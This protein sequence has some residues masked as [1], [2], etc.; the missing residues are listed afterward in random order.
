MGWVLRIFTGNVGAFLNFDEPDLLL[1]DSTM[2]LKDAPTG[3]LTETLTIIFNHHV[4]ANLRLLEVCAGL[5]A[6]Q[7]AASMPAARGSI[8]ETLEHIVRSEQSYFSRISTG[9]PLHRPDNAPP[10]NFDPTGP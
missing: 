7:L 6:E 1:E 3:T 8:Q 9:K 4:W 5:T 2:E 10:N